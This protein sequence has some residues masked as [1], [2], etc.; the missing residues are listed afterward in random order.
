VIIGYTDPENSTAT[1]QFEALA[2]AM[3]P[4][5]VFGITDDTAL[6]Q[7]DSVH[8][9]AIV[10]C[11]NTADE[12]CVLPITGDLDELQASIRKASLPVIIDLHHEIHED[13]LD[14]S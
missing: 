6:A 8:A 4:E 3:H 11:N 9:P 10:V 13:L 14:V 5:F 12:G 7:A 2:N 1:T